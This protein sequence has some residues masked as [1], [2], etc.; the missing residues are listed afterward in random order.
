MVKHKI[1]MF[2]SGCPLCQEAVEVVQR[3]KCPECT[4]I[5]YNLFEKTEYLEKARRYGVK[6]V[7]S[8]VVDGKLAIE[9][10]PTVHSVKRIL[11]V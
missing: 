5:E 11:G 3:A 4:L 10:K 1:E 9:G 2:T 7:P 8:I 6:A